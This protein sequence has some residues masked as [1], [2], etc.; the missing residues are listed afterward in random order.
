[1]GMLTGVFE[2]KDKINR[3]SKKK[4]I[5]KKSSLDSSEVSTDMYDSLFEH[6]PHAVYTLD[7]EGNFISCNHTIESFIGYKPNEIKSPFHQFIKEEDLEDV[8]GYFQ[9][10]ISGFPQRYS[11]EVIHKKGH[12]VHIQVTNIPLKVDGKVSCIYGFAEDLTYL[13]KTEDE[14]IKIT[15]SLN[16]AQEVAMI[17]SWDYY[18]AEDQAYW[19]DH[20]YRLLGIE[21]REDIVTNYQTYLEFIHP[22]DRV[23]FEYHFKRAIEHRTGLDI[24]YRICRNGNKIITV[25]QKSD[26]KMDSN[27]NIIRLIGI[28]Q[29]I[30]D[31]KLTANKLKVS[32]EKFKTVAGNIE[33]GIWSMDCFSKQFVYASPGLEK[34]T[35]YSA[36]DFLKGE[37]V[38]KDIIYSEDAGEYVRLQSKLAKGEKLQ[39]QYRIIDASGEIKWVEE[40]TFPSMDSDGRLIRLD[41]IVQDISQRKES[42]EKMNYFAFHDY[43]TELPNRRKFE[44]DLEK[45]VSSCK[46]A[47]S[48][49]ALMYLDLDRFKFINDTLGHHIGDEL[50]RQVS[51]RIFSLIS[52]HGSM[53]RVGGDEFAI[54]LDAY[55]NPK[56]AVALG[57]DLIKEVE[58]PFVI[59]GYD[60]NI[61]ASVGIGIYPEDGTGLEEI[62]RNTDAALYRAKEMGKNTVQLFTKSLNIESFKLFHLENDLRKA[63]KR[64][65]F[66][67]HYQPR[68]DAVTGDIAGAEALIR[69][70][71][72]KW[73]MVS[74]V[75]FIPLAEETG[76]INEISE[77][78][79]Q[80]VCKQLKAW[81]N[82][83][84]DLVPVSVN[85]SPKNLMKADIVQT[86]IKYLTKYKIEPRLLEIEITEDSIIKNE[87][88]ALTTIGSLKSLG[89]S[90]S[91]DDFGTG[92]TSIG[93]L[94]KFNVDT[95]KIDRSFISGMIEN[96]EDLAIV[97]SI[98]LLAGG[99]Q[100]NAVAEGVETEEQRKLL[101]DLNCQ[102]I[103]GYLFSKPLEAAAFAK[104]LTLNDKKLKPQTVNKKYPEV[105]RRLFYRIEFPAP[106]KSKMTISKIK[107]EEIKIGKT[108]VSVLNMGEGGL[109]FSTKLHL[110]VND[111]LTLQF[112]MEMLGDPIILKGHTVWKQEM[113]NNEFH[114]G[115]EFELNEA[116]RE[117]LKTKL[118]YFEHDNCVKI[119]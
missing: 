118:I 62:K 48:Q 76:L 54:T 114:Y 97:K 1:M 50:L 71:H 47:K 51:K 58:K 7:L 96:K 59:E 93:Y 36:Q 23:I 43:L 79:I 63:I 4:R 17:G 115:F 77:W 83:G 82:M 31:Q 52:G 11:C 107:G 26:I 16:L 30:S 72:P 86:I 49:F 88:S 89:I 87:A 2:R 10:A 73:G 13:D 60:I 64:N 39:H 40:K 81:K 106:I 70:N 37:K 9:K 78:V 8:I 12:L 61:T 116:E 90:I 34:L 66:V 45:M 19:S 3:R 94:K 92:Y 18:V 119:S 24:E 104:F 100:L 25:R 80:K 57:H 69:W 68:V 109:A 22:E 53:Y 6:L 74:P 95:I 65:E 44:D 42:E 102:F 108:K 110:P 85:L 56:D 32:E 28:L 84:C 105:N 111:D 41:G 33:I 15:N 29:D 98:I 99:F 113:A 67:L 46:E 35:G 20:M 55:S 101:Q 27:G 103:Q 21:N 91:L 14:L 5:H 117:N 38:W 75:E 112:E